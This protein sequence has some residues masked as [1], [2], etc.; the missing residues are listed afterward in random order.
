MDSLAAAFS[1]GFQVSHDPNTTAAQH[2]RYSQYKTKGDNFMQKNRRRR[3]LDIQKQHRFDAVAHSRRLAD[4]Y[5]KGMEKEEEEVEVED[6]E[7]Q[8]SVRKP[9]RYYRNQLMMSE[10][11][12]EVPEEFEEEWLMVLCPVAKRTLVVASHGKTVAY[13]KAG[14]RNNTFHSY[15]PGGSR[16]QSG[17]YNDYTIM[18]CLFHEVT[19]TYWILDL[20][21]W[22]SMPIYETETEFRFYWL[23]QNLQEFPQ[24]GVK[25]RQNPFSFQAL[26]RFP[27]TPQAIEEALVNSTF[28]IDGILFF[29]KRTH[30]MFG[31]T[32]LVVWLKPYMLQDVLNIPVPQRYLR[33]M[34][35]TYIDY[36]HH[37][38]EVKADKYGNVHRRPRNKSKPSTPDS[39]HSDSNKSTPGKTD[40]KAESIEEKVPQEK[41]V[42]GMDVNH[43]GQGD[44]GALTAGTSMETTASAEEVS[45]SEAQ[46]KLLIQP[47]KF[48]LGNMKMCDRVLPPST[49][50]TSA[51]EQCKA[52]ILSQAGGDVLTSSDTSHMEEVVVSPNDSMTG[53][54]SQSGETG[55]E[56]KT[57]Q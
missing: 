16:H 52:D 3:L 15:L 14:Y 12:V 33:Q 50:G 49:E 6:M 31:S 5:W 48:K 7:V 18:D 41:K 43:V 45:Q 34:P 39:K 35:S 47:T 53:E 38:A 57:K 51:N 21:C 11:L 25:S 54:Q 24:L 36:A 29:H 55:K 56:G 46:I 30:Y 37:I 40:D 13:S 19:G 44:G 23:H 4:D 20:M 22:K 32:P 27:C 42:L 28:E 1:S 2:P 9:G 8:V 26:P 10:W 17:K